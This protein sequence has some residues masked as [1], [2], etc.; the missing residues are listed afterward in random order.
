MTHTLFVRSTGRALAYG[1]GIAAGA[2]ATC[3][4]TTWLRYGHARPAAGRGAVRCWTVSCPCTR[5][6]NDTPPM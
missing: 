6:R 4:A 1:A 5:W 2:Y 3:A